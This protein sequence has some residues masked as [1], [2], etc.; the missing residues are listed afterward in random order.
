MTDRGEGSSLKRRNYL[1]LDIWVIT[2]SLIGT[3]LISLSSALTNLPASL[4]WKLLTKQIISYLIG[5]LIMYSVSKVQLI[6]LMRYVPIITL[7][8]LIILILPLTPLGVEV[9]GSK[10]WVAIGFITFQPSEL[11]KL[12]IILY[13][14]YFTTYKWRLIK[15]YRHGFLPPLIILLL[16]ALLIEL[17][18]D[19]GNLSIIAS[20]FLATMYAG[21]AKVSHLLSL[22]LLFLTGFCGLVLIKPYRV[23]RILAFIDPWADPYGSGYNIIQSLLAHGRGKI[24]GVGLGLSLQK[25]YYLPEHHTDF[26][27]SLIGEELGLVGTLGLATLYLALTILGVKISLLHKDKAGK[28]VAFG[29]AFAIGF[30]A[31]INMG[32]TISLFPVTGITLPLVSY[33]GSSVIVTCT[34]LGLLLSLAHG[35]E[36][37]TCQSDTK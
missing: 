1:T 34:M 23:K 27:F 6:R 30:Q 26:I 7:L 3:G 16:M 17:E 12:V 5:L 8:T 22:L 28:M 9:G 35:V 10:A 25:L 32:M 31:L 24:W 18:P 11:A 15:D 29:I 13:T 14:A 19:L 2:F 33:G 37:G 4:Y 20:I 36:R 21:G